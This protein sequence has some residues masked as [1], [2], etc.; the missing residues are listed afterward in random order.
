[1]VAPPTLLKI[2]AAVASLVGVAHG[3][4]DINGTTVTSMVEAVE[5]T[6]LDSE[7][8]FCPDNG[9][10]TGTIPSEIGLLLSLTLV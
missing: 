6:A 5:A 3:Q 10:L 9:G 8:I 1:M 2:C 7:E 4:C